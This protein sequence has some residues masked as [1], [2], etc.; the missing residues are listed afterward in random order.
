MSVGTTLVVGFD[1]KAVKRGL[2][3]LTDSF[4]GLGKSAAGVTK[5]AAGVGAIAVGGAVAVG[6]L[7]FKINAIGEEARASDERLRNIA[8]SM[9]IFGNEAGTV[10]DRLLELADTQ[11]RLLGID[12]DTIALTQAKLLTFKELAK[13]ANTVGGAFDRATMAALDMSAAGFGEAE[14]NA[15]SLGKALNDPIK[16]ITA[17]G[18]AGITFTESE[19]KVIEALVETNKIAKAQDLI[20]KA[21]ESQV[22]GTAAATTTASGRI[23]VALAQVVEEFAKPFSTG[24]DGLPGALENVFPQILEKANKLGNVFS[25]AIGDSVAGN[26]EKLEAIGNLIGTI[27]AEASKK[28][29]KSSMKGIGTGVL[30]GVDFAENEIRDFT[31][32][33]KLIG[34]S[35]IGDRS[36]DAANVTGKADTQIMMNRIQTAIDQFSKGNLGF[37]PGTGNQFRFA[38]AEETS[39]LSDAA[40]NKVIEVLQRIESNTKTGSKM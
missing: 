13:S 17:L 22:G 9:G 1:G 12:D 11:G 8:K 27:L 33:S 38:G 31:G 26:F 3:G 39:T 15:V 21:I 34:K 5:F 19:K 32:L 24:F 4:K 18:K 16:G 40:G 35:N 30:K 20:L 23:K 37:V 7:A 2:A 14:S 25:L 36:A 6:A 28:T 10:A 29:F